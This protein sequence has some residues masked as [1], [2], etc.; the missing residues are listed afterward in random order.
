MQVGKNAP[1][2]GAIRISVQTRAEMRMGV[3]ESYSLSI[4]PTGARLHAPT[5]VG[6]LRGLATLR[7]LVRHDGKGTWL[8]AVSI[9]DAPAFP[10]RG[11]MIDAARHF[12]PVGVLERNLDAME[13]VKLNT[14]HLHLSDNEGFR[15]ESKVFSRLQAE[16]SDGDFYTQEQMRG[17]LDYAARRGILVVPE[18]DMPGHS[19]SW[20]A[21]YPELASAPGPYRAG[22][23]RYPGL[24]PQST[25]ADG[26]RVFNTTPVPTFDP[27]RESTYEFLDK[28]IGEM[29]GLFPAPYFH[30]GGDENNGAAWRANPAIVAFMKEKGFADTVA[31]QAY[32]VDRVKQIVEKHGKRMTAWEEAYGAG[33]TTNTVVEAWIPGSATDFRKVAG[34][35]GNEVMVSNGFYLDIFLP[36]SVHYLNDALPAS[37]GQAT[38]PIGGEGAMWSE[39]A[40]GN[41]IEQRIWP[42]AGAVAERL[43]TGGG[44]LDVDGMYAR[45]FRLSTFLDGEGIR[46]EAEYAAQIK[47][48]AGS[49]SPEPVR[50]LLDALA[51]VRGYHRLEVQM[52]MVS[53]GVPEPAYTRVTDAVQEDS[54]PK[55][56]FRA[57]V[58]EWLKDRN[59]QAEAQLRKWL[60]L[61]A[62]N[63]A[64]LS[65]YWGQSKELGEVRGHSVR[66]AE[67]AHAGL[68]LLDRAKRGEIASA[69]EA[70]EVDTLLKAAKASDGDTE[71]T[72]V[73]E[74]EGL[75]HGA[76]APEPKTYPLI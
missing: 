58:A 68:G 20:F 61:W 76:L 53:M 65:E 33:K 14:L 64:A 2:P 36:A 63:D 57:A 22:P 35:N 43:W 28:F 26:T 10:W 12:I 54:E 45:L 32:F 72:V 73:P 75:F 67:L 56:A 41:N 34:N 47:H 37:G 16:G 40:D 38:S 3:D 31:L 60:E 46:H 69:A 30:I 71:I 15:I 19:Q 7:Q 39:L 17:I 66:L 9:E 8:P 62:S 44:N 70:A 52:V 24:S 48:L 59:P 29:A 23:V 13:L 55:R 1:A 18:F 49:R 21:G 11:L 4:T 50:T 27:S 51:P 25:P 5:T 42:R 74:F 6:A